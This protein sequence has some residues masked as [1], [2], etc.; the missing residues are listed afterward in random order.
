V[1]TQGGLLNYSDVHAALLSGKVGG[2]GLDV[3]HTEP[4]P[5]HDPVLQHPAVVATPH[6]AGVTEVSY[7]AMA[8]RV[9]ENVGRLLAGQPPLGHV[10]HIP[11]TKR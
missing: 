1:F 4:F 8:E 5:L 7:R 10:N 11:Q 9:A 2:L 3:F 6:V